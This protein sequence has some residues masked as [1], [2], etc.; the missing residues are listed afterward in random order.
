M[1]MMNETF[2]KI[3]EIDVDTPD[4]WQNRIFLTFDID[5]A[6]DEVLK[7][8]IDLVEQAK[9]P[10]TWF[11]THETPLLEELRS[12]PKFELGIHPNF[13]FLLDG[14]PYK[15]LN[16]EEVVDSFL[17]IVPEANSVRC[18][19]MTQSTKLLQVFHDKGLTHDCNHF[20]PEQAGFEVKPWYIW[21]GMIKVPYFW[22]DDIACIYNE[23]TPVSQMVAQK[24]T[25]VFDFHP[26]HIFLNTED[27]ERHEQTRELHGRPNDLSKYCFEGNGT[28][29]VLKFL[30]KLAYPS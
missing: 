11:V 26:I 30:L 7:D 16:A 15:G 9:V 12:N 18:H 17:A 6:H 5:W 25:K 3:S 1:Q 13:N 10:A 4:T 19:S 22:E 8:T 14:D 29:T 20:I 2:G 24:G 23:N 21:N 28:R 27:L